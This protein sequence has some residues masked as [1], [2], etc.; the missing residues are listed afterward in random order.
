MPSVSRAEAADA[1]TLDYVRRYGYAIIAVP[2]GAPSFAYTL[3]LSVTWDH[4]EILV[5]APSLWAG[6]SLSVRATPSAE[7]S[8]ACR[9]PWWSCLVPGACPC[10]TVRSCRR[11]RRSSGMPSGSCT[12]P[13]CPPCNWS[14]PMPSV[15][16]VVGRQPRRPMRLRS[17]GSPGAGPG[18]GVHCRGAGLL[19]ATGIS[20]TG[21]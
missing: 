4:P 2:D 11:T 5:S 17:D 16:R 8:A 9:A 6:S 7:A 10:S 3:G 13:T 14:I 1:Q 19:P 21:P 12:V 20:S 15:R 18:A